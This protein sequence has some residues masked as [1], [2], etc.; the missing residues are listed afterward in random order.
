VSVNYGPLTLSLKIKEKYVQI[1][2]TKTAM[3]DSH[4]QATADP[5]KWPSYEIHPDSDWNYG[6]LA[7]DAIDDI[8]GE[9]WNF[10]DS[11]RRDWPE[12]NFPWTPE[13]VPFSLKFQGKKI[14]G[15]QI[16]QYGLCA[17]VPQSPVKTDQPVEEIELIPMGAARLRISAFPTVE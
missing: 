11:M 8:A 9:G 10:I 4:W 1:D 17:P 5:T 14:P 6:L 12:D 3:G 13:S 7:D 2:S 15:W 16:D